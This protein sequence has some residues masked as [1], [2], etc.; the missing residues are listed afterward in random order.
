MDEKS[1]LMGIYAGIDKILYTTIMKG[2]NKT[3]FMLFS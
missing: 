3:A 2:Q 1:P